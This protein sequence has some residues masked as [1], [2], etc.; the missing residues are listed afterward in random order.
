MGSLMGRKVFSSHLTHSP[1][2]DNKILRSSRIQLNEYE[3]I[4][5]FMFDRVDYI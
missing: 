3:K 2:P 5:K 4:R 1:D